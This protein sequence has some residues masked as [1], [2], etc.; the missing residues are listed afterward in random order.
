MVKW[1]FDFKNRLKN[2]DS[3]NFIEK[4]EMYTFFHEINNY[5]FFNIT[6][7]K[8]STNLYQVTPYLL[9]KMKYVI[10]T[11]LDKVIPT[12]TKLLILCKK[13]YISTL[14]MKF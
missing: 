7:F 4:S 6:L 9:Q 5:I 10:N 12:N 11:F 1:I 14:S 8:K 3:S 13:V 2:L